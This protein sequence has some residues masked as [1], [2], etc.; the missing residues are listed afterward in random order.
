MADA[1]ISALPTATTP[2]AGT[3]VV[4]VVQG[5]STK[6]VAVSNLTAGRSVSAS[7]LITTGAVGVGSTPTTG[8]SLEIGKTISGAA[9]SVAIYNIGVVQSGVV[10]VYYN[11]SEIGTAATSFTVSTAYGYFARQGTVGAGSAITSQY[12]FCSGSNLYGATN[13]YG[14]LA[15]DT[16]GANAT[17]GK[18]CAGYRSTIAA[19][20]GG[21]TTYNFWASGT[22]PNVFSG[23]VQIN[24]AGILG[25]GSGSGGTVTQIT[26][27]TTGVTID[28]TNGAITLVSAA[29]TSTWQTFTVTNNK[30]AATDVIIVNQKSGTDLNEI[31]VTSVAAGSFNISFRTTGGT[32]TETPVFSFAVIKATTA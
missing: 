4:P 18:L 9:T 26:S 32:T 22:A 12:G 14:F 15:E 20:S 27:R 25:Y 30:V 2:L 3:E 16:G 8:V 7:S 29:G 28:K 19:A 17:T 5:G 13:N 1:K 24:G 21:G 10:S 6:Q 31:H 11:R 23:D